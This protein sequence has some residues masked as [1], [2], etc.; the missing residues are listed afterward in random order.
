MAA[1][2]GMEAMARYQSFGFMEK[3]SRAQ[4][5]FRSWHLVVSV[6]TKAPAPREAMAAM[7][8]EQVIAVVHSATGAV[9]RVLEAR[10]APLALMVKLDKK[11][12]PVTSKEPL[13]SQIT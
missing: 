8:A 12:L 3:P 7:A 10:Q 13:L 11:V 2:V 4:I 1:M 5:S 9:T 6:A